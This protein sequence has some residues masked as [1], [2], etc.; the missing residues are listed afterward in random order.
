MR[1]AP[2]RARDIAAGI[3]AHRLD[4][5]Q[6]AAEDLPCGAVIPGPAILDQADT[7]IFVDPD[8]QAEVDGFGNLILSRKG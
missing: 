8:L 2:R 4:L 6:R 5:L 7:T 3:T 1:A